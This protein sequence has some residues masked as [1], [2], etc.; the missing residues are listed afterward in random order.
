MTQEQVANV[1]G[2]SPQTVS[3]VEHE[4]L[5]KFADAIVDLAEADE[6]FMVLLQEAFR[7]T[8]SAI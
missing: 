8:K 5:A 1:L 4:A 3:R 2:C 7:C 6:R